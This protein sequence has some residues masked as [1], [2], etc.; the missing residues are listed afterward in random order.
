MNP[1]LLSLLTRIA[2]TLE[3][4]E[5]QSAAPT[6][7]Q[8]APAA[9]QP[10]L[11]LLDAIARTYGEQT[12]SEVAA[13]AAELAAANGTPRRT[14]TPGPKWS[15]LFP[16]LREL[17]ETMRN[18]T[19]MQKRYERRLEIETDPVLRAFFEIEIEKAAKAA[20]AAHREYR[21][22]IKRELQITAEFANRSN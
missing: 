15:E 14:R 19:K 20:K 3:R 16:H 17:L 1:Q 7:E 12:A 11:P 13:H 8:P 6:Q 5:R 4:I 2:E 10:E 21:A 9:A 18:Q 22:F